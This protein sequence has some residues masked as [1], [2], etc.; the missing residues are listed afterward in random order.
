[1]AEVYASGI[2]PL[3]FYPNITLM[4]FFLFQKDPPDKRFAQRHMYLGIDVIAD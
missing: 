3:F 1:M 2:S 4:F